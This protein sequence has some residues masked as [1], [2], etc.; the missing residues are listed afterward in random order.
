[1]S[2]PD[3][4]ITSP[5]EGHVTAATPPEAGV[6]LS[7]HLPA[8]ALQVQAWP[9]RLADTLAAL[10]RGVGID[11]PTTPNA[12]ATTASSAG[13]LTVIMT[14]PGRWLV[15]AGD[16]LSRKL[17]DAVTADMGAVTDLGHAR[18]GFRLDG[19]RAVD[20]LAKGLPV[21]THIAQFPPGIAVQSTIHHINVL[22]HRVSEDRFDIYVFRGF[23]LSFWDWLTDAALEFGAVVISNDES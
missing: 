21:D 18:A 6:T 11:P 9:D 22:V 19:A 17:A 1:M 5:L 16:D 13:A 15:I 14:G 10:A 20:V 4:A 8:C 23:A 2:D 12:V 3:G 7:N